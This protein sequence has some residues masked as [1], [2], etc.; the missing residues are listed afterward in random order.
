MT[1]NHPPQRLDDLDA[2]IKRL[3][4][5]VTDGDA[6]GKDRRAKGG[7]GLAFTL[8]ADMVGGLVGGGLLGWGF[9]SW[10]NSAPWGLIGF[11]FLGA[12]A[13]MWNV[14]RTVRGHDAAMGFRNNPAGSSQTGRR[15]PE[16]QSGGGNGKEEG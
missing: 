3:K 12:C 16:P 1:D 7:Y 15:P 11:F 2:R 14:Y 5:E 8:A 4:D 9:D 10:L 13:G 6:A